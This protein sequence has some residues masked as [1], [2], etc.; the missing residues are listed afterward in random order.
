M[1]NSTRS[2]KKLAANQTRYSYF[3]L[4]QT[5]IDI[6]VTNNILAAQISGGGGDDSIRS[7]NANDTLIGGLGNDTLNGGDGDDY[8]FVDSAQDVIV[9]SM[10]PIGGIDTVV[11]TVS[12]TLGGGAENLILKGAATSGVGNA[13]DNNIVGN[14]L[15][16]ILNGGFG[17]DTLSGGDGNDYYMVDS[18]QDLIIESISSLGG[19]DTVA[20]ALSFTLGGGLENLILLG[21]A[22][23]GLG[24]SVANNI[25]GN[26]LANTLD[27]GLGKDT[28][29]GGEGNDYYILDNSLDSIVESS[30]SGGG[31]DTVEATFSYTLGGG[32]ENLVLKGASTLGGF[33]NSLDNLIS[34]NSLD[35]VLIGNAGNDTLNGRMGNDSM[36]GGE[37]NDYYILDSLDK[38]VES[39][40][41]G[42]GID[43]V[44][45]TSS[46]TLG[47]GVENLVLKGSAERG[48]GNILS[49][50]IIGNDG[51]NTIDGGKGIDTMSGD[52]GNDFYIVDDNQ[53]VVIEGASSLAGNDTVESTASYILRG[54]IENLL[55][56]GPLSLTG[57]GNSLDNRI[58]GNSLS[59]TLIGNAGNDTL[60]GREGGDSLIG[61][62]GDDY[63]L[64][65]NSLDNI[66]ETILSGG[67]DTVE[68]TVSYTLGGGIENLL[69]K[70]NSARGFGNSLNNTILGN[71]LANT[72]DGGL[73]NDTLSGGDGNDYYIVDNSL[74]SILESTSSLGG[75][76]TVEAAFSH[77]LGGGLENLVLRGSAER[78]L[79]NSVANNIIGNSLANTLDGGLGND[80]LSGGDGNDYYILDNSLDKIVESTLSGGGIDTVEAT[81][82]YTL[83]GGAENLVLKNSAEKGLGNSVANNIIG[84]SL[85]NTLDGGLGNDTL[86]GGEGNDYYI[87]DNSLDNVVESTLSDAGIDTIEATF[88][89][90]LGGGLENLVLK[91]ASTFSGFGN[92]L[93]N[94][95]SGNSLS[96]TLIGNAG[97]DTLDG[98]AGIDS[99]VGGEGNDYYILDNVSDNILESTSPSGGIDTVEAT[100]S[101]TL[102]GG[103]EN[104][105]LK[106]ATSLRG[107]GN[108]LDNRISGNSLTNTLIGN[109]GNDTLDG[110]AGA[111]SMIGGA[112]ED[113]YYVDTI[114]TIAGGS[115]VVVELP[116]SLNGGIDTVLSSVASYS[117][118]SNV[119]NL[120]LIGMASR[121]I[122]NS[123][124]NRIT[125]NAVSNSLVGGEGNDTLDGALGFDTMSGGAGD[126]VYYVDY[127]FD[128][129]QE[130]IDGGFDNV[131][132]SG[133]II[134]SDNIEGVELIGDD[135]SDVIGNSLDNTIIGNAG[136]NSFD[137]GDGID[138]IRGAQ[139]DDFIDGGE[140]DDTAVY[141][142]SASD[143]SIT[144]IEGSTQYILTDNRQDASDGIDTLTGIENL[145]FSDTTVSISD[146]IGNHKSQ[147]LTGTAEN[148]VLI[149]TFE[150]QYI[151]GLGGDDTINGSGGADTLD[152]GE[153]A[154]ILDGGA[155]NDTLFIDSADNLIDGNEGVDIIVS[156]STVALTETRF[157][158]V[159][160]IILY[161]EENISATGDD[162]DNQLIGNIGDNSLDGAAG[163]DTLA[164]GLGDDVYVIDNEGDIVEELAEEGTDL[165]ASSVNHTLAD[166]V[167]NLNLVG[168]E[169]IDGTG[170]IL[171]NAILGNSAAN[172]LDGGLNDDTLV[173]D[174]LIG[175]E[176]DDTLVMNSLED[177]IEGGDGIDTVESSLDYVLGDDVENLTLTGE[178]ISGTGNTG[179]NQI[180]GNAG[181]NTLDGG[182]GSDQLTGG[183]GDDEYVV[184]AYDLA[185]VENEEEG[186]D[187]VV[188][189]F[190]YILAD[191]IENL[192]LTGESATTG[193]G[194]SLANKI[195]GNSLDNILSG[196]EGDDTLIGDEGADSLVGGEGYDSLVGG[197][198]NDTLVVDNSD[199]SIDGGDGTDL[200]VSEADIDLTDGRFTSVENITLA[201][202]YVTDETTG[203]TVLAET[204]PISATGD[205]LGNTIIG[206]IAD[207][208]LNGG[209]GADILD[210]GAGNDTLF[211]DSA[212]TLIDGN[213][214]V[215]SIVS[216]STVALTETRFA[217]VEN[218]LLTGLDSLS[219]TGD[220]GDNQI[221]GNDGD[222]SLLGGL[223]ADYLDGGLGADSLFGGDGIDT[224]IGGDGNDTL[225]IDS[226]DAMVDG[227]DGTADWVVADFN[228]SLTSVYNVE[229]ILLSGS[230]TLTATGDESANFI[231]GNSGANTITG[232]GGLD[233]LTGNGGADV[234]V[235]GYA[236]GN[237]YGVAYDSFALIT[238]F[239][240]GTDM[241]QLKGTS[242][243]NYTVNSTDPTQVLITS[244][245]A[246]VGLVAKI[247]VVSG[248]A[249]NILSNATFLS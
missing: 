46:Y 231:V 102:G 177:L 221:L 210:G 10:L 219:A 232:G 125:G 150:G 189:D 195:T 138:I 35:N 137:G 156:D 164:G 127:E 80:T 34:G 111:D 188:A 114:S 187:L 194:N 209:E 126:D 113:V 161:G 100:F 76:D 81:F 175:G 180:V 27:G 19:N 204:Q 90:A 182:E 5:G 73:G 154:D 95:I 207:N 4:N 241:L 149:A 157:T 131:F 9:E 183:A 217:N 235:I 216:D 135:S 123:L 162:N 193:T 25:T 206:N 163:A 106:G 61:G 118:G 23:R 72:L 17:D 8:Y 155:G 109:S 199:L 143:Y 117:L 108:D 3:S 94:R 28:L 215:D 201:D 115:D 198:G 71:S 152:G 225:L 11:S 202:V 15:A 112:G 120:V 196:M 122:G 208:S 130:F 39:T 160:N 184:D 16:N 93:N 220:D 32:L 79:G 83:G 36:V 244:T 57:E 45:T 38:V 128:I 24:N 171:A 234:F 181:D 222:N 179:D 245:D 223:G 67:I 166:H 75:L 2:L 70:G 158:N 227:G 174:T 172:R 97:H 192:I 133:S 101:C 21:S 29:S 99:L 242:V 60:D 132:A 107:E 12:F 62:E 212:D 92:S 141:S 74:D 110:R 69:L 146:F 178:A 77:T 248:T 20:S 86:V 43:T 41:S 33:G 197:A 203:E 136:D 42:G 116:A 139:G 140:S 205:S 226:L 186:T 78:G 105:D 190:D 229:N 165:V 30:L 104:L 48:G 159:E 228:V 240:V 84:N 144:L 63:Y 58:S 169:A 239:T 52:A 66:L 51:A 56:K 7:G 98:Q 119:E 185:I 91:G 148:D 44:E 129:V 50:N 153:G 145:A 13:M 14:S 89:Y 85:A 54:G 124:D 65:D 53:D 49:N 233:T 168:E 64:V 96:N 6:V 142:G 26:S 249:A 167:E 230:D 40:L 18:P 176:G 55:L 237:A 243:S 238:D 211:I 134:L 22:E 236:T 214:G 200:V 59:N 173:G 147:T 1:S 246:S 88:S 151:S 87:L 68:S 37:G 47:G 121:G 218:I 170:N 82:S 31:I 191:N 213:D 247:N 224:L 103:L